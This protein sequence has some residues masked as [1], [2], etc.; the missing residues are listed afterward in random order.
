MMTCEK[1]SEHLPEYARGDVRPD[2]SAYIAGHL[3]VCRLCADEVIELQRIAEG[4]QKYGAVL[5]EDHI[6]PMILIEH[7]GNPRMFEPDLRNQVER[8]L[9]LCETCQGEY[10]VLKQVNESLPIE[11]PLTPAVVG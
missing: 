11:E 4:I 5:F 3:A 1:T 6:D 2:Q 7:A 9:A 8:H 10:D